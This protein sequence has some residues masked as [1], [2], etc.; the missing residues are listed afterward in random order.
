MNVERKE[1]LFHAVAGSRQ[2]SVRKEQDLLP[3]GSGCLLGEAA[4]GSS[5]LLRRS[6]PEARQ[7]LAGSSPLQARAQNC[8]TA[9]EARS[10]CACSKVNENPPSTC[11]F[12]SVSSV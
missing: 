1:S 3:S 7:G 8:V 9:A 12:M 6:H 5:A 2:V 4:L 10:W 11:T